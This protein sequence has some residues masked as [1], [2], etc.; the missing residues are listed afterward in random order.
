MSTISVKFLHNWTPVCWVRGYGD[1]GYSFCAKTVHFTAVAQAL[2]LV[3]TTE[4]LIADSA[5]HHCHCVVFL[6]LESRETESLGTRA[7]GPA[8][9]ARSR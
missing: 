7:R 1:I 5:R 6:F 2:Q 3:L 8:H 4:Q 9:C